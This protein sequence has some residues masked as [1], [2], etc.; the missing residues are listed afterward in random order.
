LSLGT[1]AILGMAHSLD[2]LLA[3]WKEKRKVVLENQVAKRATQGVKA[4]ILFFDCNPP[5][6]HF[7]QKRC[8][9]L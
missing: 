4:N 8:E 1:A 9:P 3:S 5:A 2:E 7:G 6:R